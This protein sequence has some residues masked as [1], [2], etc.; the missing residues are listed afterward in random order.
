MEPNES[1]NCTGTKL[2]G[3]AKKTSKSSGSSISRAKPRAPGLSSRQLRYVVCVK[4]GGNIDLELLKVYRVRRDASAAESGLLRV[5][6]NSGEDYLFPKDFFQPIQA[7]PR[8]F[9]LVEGAV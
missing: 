6:D 8:L 5:I 1:Q 4:T 3:S 9:R 7:S 2:M